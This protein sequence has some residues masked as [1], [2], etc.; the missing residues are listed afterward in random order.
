MKRLK[1]DFLKIIR[2]AKSRVLLIGLF[3]FI[4]SFSYFYQQ[5][6][7]LNLSDEYVS[8]SNVYL[9]TYNSLTQESL[10]T[11]QG[12]EIDRRLARNQ[13]IS[14]MLAFIIG[15]EEGNTVQDLEEVV[16]DFVD[17][18][19]ELNENI[20]F[21][22]E[23][24]DFPQ[25]D[26]L[27]RLMP[28]R[29]IAIEQ[30]RM[31]D[32]MSER[33]IQVDANQTSPGMALYNLIQLLSGVFIIIIAAVSGSDSFSRDQESNWSVSQG[34]PITWQRQ[35][36]ARTLIHWGLVWS[37]ILIGIVTSFL[38]SLIGAGSTALDYPVPLYQGE[39]VAYIS[40]LQYAVIVTILV[41]IISYLALKLAIGM[42]FI[43]RNIYLTVALVLGVFFIPYAFL[44][45]PPFSD[46]NPLLYLQIAPAL[47]QWW[48]PLN[49]Q[50]W[51]MLL[52][53]AVFYI[54]IE[55]VFLYVFTLIPTRIG[56]LERR[57]K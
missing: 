25:Y 53:F 48:Y 24:E 11:E 19:K 4:G 44:I 17:Q 54:V 6:E 45:M 52:S 16:G 32:Y 14:G 26:T 29:E 28:P 57:R 36:H 50:L 34:L 12:Q 18:S 23:Q 1:W 42:S 55:L 40:V 37:V 35:W 56:K 22:Y 8:N 46:L 20:L 41:M 51:Q 31:Y 3:L 30:F 43:F 2:D 33:D 47:E 5:G 49:T 9:D 39:N 27:L 38:I 21:F 7:F 10:S 13:S 15:Q